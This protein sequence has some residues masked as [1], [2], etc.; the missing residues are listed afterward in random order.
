MASVLKVTFISCTTLKLICYSAFSIPREE[1]KVKGLWKCHPVCQLNKSSLMPEFK[2]KGEGNS[3]V[4]VRRVE[5]SKRG[6]V[7]DPRIQALLILMWYLEWSARDEEPYFEN[8]YYG[9]AAEAEM[10]G[11]SHCYDAL[12]WLLR[13]AQ[14]SYSLEQEQVVK[15]NHQGYQKFSVKITLPFMDTRREYL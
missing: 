2:I 4:W 11:G 12:C 6:V 1:V 10:G 15:S 8:I 13:E 14:I 5:I 9:L 3:E 7:S